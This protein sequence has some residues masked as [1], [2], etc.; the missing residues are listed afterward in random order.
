MAKAP[1]KVK[2]I[3]PSSPKMAPGNATTHP[4]IIKKVVK[5]ANGGNGAMNPNKAKR[6]GK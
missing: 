2:K 4:T 5:I 6:R 3:S 1:M